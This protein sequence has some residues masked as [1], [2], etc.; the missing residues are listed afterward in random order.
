MLNRKLKILRELLQESID[1]IDASSETTFRR[2]VATMIG[3]GIP[4]DW[5]EIY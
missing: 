2:W 4:I 5:E 1:K 3:N